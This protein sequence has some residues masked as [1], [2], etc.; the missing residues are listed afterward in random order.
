M[1]TWTLVHEANKKGLEIEF[2]API[3]HAV[4][5]VTLVDGRQYYADGQNGFVEEIKTNIINLS[6]G[7]RILEIINHGD[8]QKGQV[9]PSGEKRF[10]P[11]FVFVDKDG[12]V[13][14]TMSNVDSM[15]YKQR[16]GTDDEIL[17]DY[18]DEASRVIKS[19]GIIGDEADKIMSQYE[20]EAS[21]VIKL[22]PYAK[23]FKKRVENI[24]LDEMENIK[25]E[26]FPGLEEFRNS[27]QYKN[28]EI[29]KNGPSSDY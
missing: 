15:L 13:S 22:Q 23:E 27:P 9:Y 7:S 24:D 4:G 25:G 2:G 11:K 18:R 21:K 1:S 16:G 12:G 20:K 5:I 10:F 28:D 8:I 17:K 19:K 3:G 29:R 6:N 14:S 26:L